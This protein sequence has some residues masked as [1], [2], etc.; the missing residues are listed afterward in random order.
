MKLSGWGR[1]PVHETELVTPRSEAEL[2]AALARGGAVIARGNGRAYGDS[3]IGPART[4]GMRRFDRMIAF[5]PDTGQLVAE[6]GVLLS[7]VIARFLPRGW[8]PMVTPGTKFV[9]LGGMIAADVHGKNHHRD[10]SMRASVDWL[11]LMGPGGSV[12]RCSRAQNADLF[13]WTLGGMGLTGIVLR[14]AIRLRPVESAWIRQ[15]MIPAPDLD[16][17]MAAFEAHGEATYSV[18]W[19]DCLSTGA[20]MGRSLVMLG[21]HAT[22]V[23]LPHQHRLHPFRTARKAKRTVPFDLPGLTLNA[24][25]VSA[26]NAL[27]WRNGLRRAGT[28]YVDWDSYFYPLDAILGWNRV[29]GRRGLLQFQ[30]ALPLRGARAGLN[31][32][33]QAISGARAGCFLSVLKRFGPEEGRFSFP[34]EGYTLALDFPVNRRTL[35]LMER[36]DALTIEHGGRFYLAKDSRLTA[37]TQHA[38]DPRTGAFT[39]LRRETGLAPV[40]RSAQSER[41]SI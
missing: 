29:Y 26:F 6:A 7:D 11:D 34:M 25:T 10:G 1:Y 5:D 41:L 28:T 21:E 3:A 9:T 32:L 23:E 31:A 20:A 14:A 35:A 13:D 24:L 33:L 12:T 39:F 30:C 18:A 38:A 19:I 22:A 36:L 2:G 27:Y 17:A 37:E 8:F 40:F 4:L 15:E 16:A